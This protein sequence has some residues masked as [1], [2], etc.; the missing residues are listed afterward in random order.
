MHTIS[1]PEI[2]MKM[3]RVKDDTHEE[4]AKIGSYG[5][6]MDDILKRLIENWKKSHK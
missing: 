3:I 2:N 4:L 5:E 6:T 1:K